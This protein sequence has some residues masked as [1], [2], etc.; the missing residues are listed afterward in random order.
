MEQNTDAGAPVAPVVDSV[1]QNSGNGLKIATAIACIV[2]ACGIGFGVYGMFFNKIDNKVANNTDTNTAIDTNS[3]TKKEIPS[4]S[5]I[6]E[7]LDDKYGVK[8]FNNSGCGG[9]TVTSLF[10]HEEFGDRFKLGFI[11]KKYFFNTQEMQYNDCDGLCEYKTI[12]YDEINEKNHLYFGNSNDLKKEDYDDLNVLGIGEAKYIEEADSFR[13]KYLGGL[14][15]G[16]S[17]AGFYVD[18]ASVEA[19]EDGFIALASVFHLD[20]TEATSFGERLS[21]CDSSA[22]NCPDLDMESLKTENSIYEFKFIE[23]DGEYKLTGVTKK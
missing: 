6:A 22:Y 20:A 8:E 18:I 21:N 11:I 19:G 2:A 15:C 23:E 4:K 12:S 13:V 10:G 1:K 9:N 5:S 16:Y 14:G 3:D 7:V 17:P